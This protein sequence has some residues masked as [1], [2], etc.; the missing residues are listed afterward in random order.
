MQQPVIP[1]WYTHFNNSHSSLRKQTL[2]YNQTIYPKNLL[3]ARKCAGNKWLYGKCKSMT[4]F[5]KYLYWCDKHHRTFY[6][7]LT[8]TA[9]YMYI[10]IDYKLKNAINA[11]IKTNLINNLISHLQQFIQSYGNYF[12]L[13]RTTKLHIWD[14]TRHNKFSI[15]IIDTNN[16]IHYK[17]NCMFSTCF[18]YW[19]HSNGIIPKECDVDTNIY[20]E[21]YQLWRLPFNHNG[22]ID[23]T[24]YLINEQMTVQ[25][26]LEITFMTN[27][28]THQIQCKF[29]TFSFLQL[30]IINNDKTDIKPQKIMAAITT[31]KTQLTN[32]KE[33]NTEHSNYFRNK[34]DIPSILLQNILNHYQINKPKQINHE[35]YIL[36]MIFSP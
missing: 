35:Q 34:N 21:K 28:Q 36:F 4:E 19:I 31:N 1:T 8:S 20:H 11:H 17:D 29:T 7:I 27:L 25:S 23:S 14:A 12:G 10:D 18:K 6:A 2:I 22:S 13:T 26:Q 5:I 24:L 15:H 30:N 3:I 33:H 32:Q 9:R 16:I